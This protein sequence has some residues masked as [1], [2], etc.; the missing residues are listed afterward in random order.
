MKTRSFPSR[1]FTLVETLIATML[2]M[3]LGLVGWQV[4]RGGLFAFARNHS[5]NQS[6]GQ[7]RAAIAHVVR[8]LEASVDDAQLVSFSGTQ[9]SADT[10]TYGKGIRFHRY[11][12]GGYKIRRA[13]GA[14][15]IVSGAGSTALHYIVSTETSVTLDYAAGTPAPRAGDRLFLL[16]PSD[17]QETVSGGTSP[18]KKPGRKI[19]AVS[20]GTNSATLTLSSAPGK[21]ILADNPCYIVREGAYICVDSG[22]RRELR[23][24]DDTGDLAKF[25]RVTW[26]LDMSPSEKDSGGTTILPFEVRTVSGKKR[27]VLDL[28]MRVMDFNAALTRVKPT[29]EFNSYLRTYSQVI[30]KNSSGLNVTQ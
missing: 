2:V 24:Y 9:F 5:L 4:L 11:I 27:V 3:V 25:T 18:G 21:N 17:I 16:F 19:S 1:G 23:Y 8:K 7:S 20:V 12:A 14:S 26:D 13:T 15:D 28:P 22:N 10:A 29:D 30:L 6:A